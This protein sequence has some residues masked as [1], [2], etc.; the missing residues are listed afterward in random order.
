MWFCLMSVLVYE[1][2]L[3]CAD[4]AVSCCVC[5]GDLLGL[6]DGFL[7]DDLNPVVAF[8]G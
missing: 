7:A 4:H 3:I 1:A 6:L 8:D 5:G 2:A